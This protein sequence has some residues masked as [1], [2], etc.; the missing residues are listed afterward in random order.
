LPKFHLVICSSSEQR[1]YGVKISLGNLGTAIQSAVT[2]AVS[3][4]PFIELLAIG[5]IVHIGSETSS[6]LGQ[7]SFV[8]TAK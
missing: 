2:S 6:G 8:L 4:S 1:G 3:F 5:E 7:Y